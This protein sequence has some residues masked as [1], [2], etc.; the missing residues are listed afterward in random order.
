MGLKEYARAR[1]DLFDEALDAQLAPSLA[2]AYLGRGHELYRDP[3][4][5]FAATYLSDSMKGILREVAEAALGRGARRIFPLFS[6]YGGGKTH[7]LLAIVHAARRPEALGRLDPELGALY[8]KARPRVVVLDGES[9]ELCPNPSKPLSLAPYQVRTIWGSLAHQLG[10]Y[11]QLREEDEKAYAPTAEALHRLLGEE[12]AVILVDEIA[13]YATR[14]L[15]SGDEGLRGYGKNVIAFVESLAKAV[16]GTRAALVVTLPLEVRE[17]EERYVDAY[18][19]AVGMIRSGLGR[20]TA[21]YDVPLRPEEIMHVL[22]RR[23]FESID[24]RRVQELRSRYLDLYS[25]EQDVFGRGAVDAASKLDATAPFHPSYLETLY[26]IVT[27]NPELQRTRDALRISR[28]VVRRI[29][30]SGEDPD[31]VM[32]WHI[33]VADDKVRGFLLTQSFASF[34]PVVDKDLLGRARQLDPTGL[35]YRV[36]LSIFL[37]TYVYGTALTPERVFPTKEDVAFMVYEESLA[38][39]TGRKPVDVQNQLNI[40][41][42]ELL[43]LQ[44]RDGRYWYNPMRSVIEIVEDEAKRV[45]PVTARERLVDALRKLAREPPPGAPR[46]GAPRL[47]DAQV[48]DEPLPLDKPA[49]YLVI[50]PRRLSDDEV[51]RIIFERKEGGGKVYRNTVAVLYPS[52]ARRVEHLLG[53]CAKLV[54]CNSVEKQLKEIYLDKDSRELQGKKLRELSKKLEEQ[55]YS[56]II[57]AFDTVAFPSGEDVVKARASP[58]ATSLAVV[59]EDTLASPDVGK[60]KIYALSFDELDHLLKSTGVAL[61][62]GEKELTVGDILSYFFTNPRL[63]FV[64]R[65]LVLQ[66]LMEGVSTLRIGLQRGSK[67]FWARVY[68]REEAPEYPS[69]EAPES[70][71]ETD[72]VLPRRLAASRLLESLKPGVAESQGRKVR[73]SYAVLIDRRETPLDQ[74]PPDKVVDVLLTSPLVRIEEEIGDRVLVTVARSAVEAA[75]GEEVAVEVFVEPV[76]PLKQP[77]SLRVSEG[78]VE[79]SSGVPPFK[80]TWRLRAPE[81]EG[82]YRFEVTATSPELERPALGA[83]AVFV[84]AE[85]VPLIRRLVA[86]ELEG[87]EDLLRSGEF[88]PLELEEGHVRLERGDLSVELTVRRVDPAV[89]PALVRE[90]MRSTGIFAPRELRALLKLGKPVEYTDETERKLSKYRGVDLL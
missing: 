12:P 69:G 66:A 83:L 78:S 20:V 31:F 51:R 15:E 75:P 4:R 23:I 21:A 38:R 54:A 43:Y 65:E 73:V 56:E 8:A 39:G 41:A 2:D 57:S 19:E 84:K 45:S 87:L 33:D 79:P 40:A 30:Q 27:R 80:A 28:L 48:G 32:P 76:E 86:K 89:F 6:L 26:D 46:E 64:R 61:S 77:V 36:A 85:R 55:L 24:E 88:G 70:V 52:D 7:L 59:A 16:E 11:A 13:K 47:F 68:R 63:P 34:A 5:F 53:L 71:L 50:S 72:I 29:L 9:D 81:A 42:S 49:H 60:A 18:R 25:R 35:L 14:F 3:E 1:S 82:E 22:K 62:E 74:L 10:R 90:L 44:E 67:L 58:R 37:R 17:G